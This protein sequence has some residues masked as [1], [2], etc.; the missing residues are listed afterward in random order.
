[1]GWISDIWD[2]FK[3]NNNGLSGRKISAAWGVSIAATYVTYKHTTNENMLKVLI[4]WL[5][6][7]CVCLGLVTIPELIKF[8]AELKNGKKD[9]Q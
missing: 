4:V 1:M 9:G 8:L 5:V 3:T 7:S 6:F 2:S